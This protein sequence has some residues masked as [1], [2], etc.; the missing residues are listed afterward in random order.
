[1]ANGSILKIFLSWNRVLQPSFTPS[2]FLGVILGGLAICD[3][4]LE[5]AKAMGLKMAMI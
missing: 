1:M 5:V 3:F 4:A 2:Y